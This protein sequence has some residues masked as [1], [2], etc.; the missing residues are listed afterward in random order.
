MQKLI[1]GLVTIIGILFSYIV[2]G[3]ELK[4]QIRGKVTDAITGQPLI[5][6]NVIVGEEADPL[7]G[8]VTDQEGS[9][10]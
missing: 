9:L 10:L 1:T 3:Q 6:A 4:Q 8:G 7:A 5:G 2:S